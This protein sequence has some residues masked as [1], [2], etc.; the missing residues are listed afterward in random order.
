M[1]CDMPQGHPSHCGCASVATISAKSTPQTLPKP[2]AHVDVERVGHVK[3]QA[4][5]STLDA[6][7]LFTERQMNGILGRLR[8]VQDRLDEMIQQNNANVKLLAKCAAK[9][10]ELEKRLG[11]SSAQPIYADRPAVVMLADW[12]IRTPTRDNLAEVAQKWLRDSVSVLPDGSLMLAGDIANSGHWFPMADYEHCM[13]LADAVGAEVVYQDGLKVRYIEMHP[14]V[15]E[16]K[17]EEMVVE[18]HHGEGMLSATM[19]KVAQVAIYL[20]KLAHE[21]ALKGDIRQ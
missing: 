21:R 5:A 2:V 17:R 8:R 10:V 7:G 9:G 4:D 1:N 18:Q 15:G 20:C 19:R 13:Q 12:L 14:L 3:W 11:I 6:E 16:V